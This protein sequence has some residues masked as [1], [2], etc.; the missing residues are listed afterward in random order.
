[1][2]KVLEYRG[3]KYS[4]NAQL[5]AVVEKRMNG[6]RTHH[7]IVNDMGAGTYYFTHEIDSKENLEDAIIKIEN[8][9]K[10]VIDEKLDGSKTKEESIMESLGYTN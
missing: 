2:K 6:T 5:N 8:R 1:M 3:Q 7:V 10:K 4:I 9:T